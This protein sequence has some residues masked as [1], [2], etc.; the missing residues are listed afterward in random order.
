VVGG[1]VTWFAY[2]GE[3]VLAEY[4]DS[5]ALDAFQPSRKFVYGSYVDEPLLLLSCSELAGGGRTETAYYYHQDRNFNVIAMTDD[6]GQVV[7]QYSYSAYGEIETLT[8]GGTKI[9]ANP[10]FFTG[11]RFDAELTIY[12]YRARYHDPAL[13]RFL[14]RDPLGYVDGMSLYEYVKGMPLISVDPHGLED[15]EL[16]ETWKHPTSG[17]VIEEYKNKDYRMGVAEGEPQFTRVN[18]TQ[19]N[20]N[21]TMGS[22]IDEVIDQRRSAAETALRKVERGA[23][24]AEDAVQTAVFCASMASP[25]D[26]SILVGWGLKLTAKNAAKVAAKLGKL[27]YKA[28]KEGGEI[29]L[30]NGDEVLDVARSRRIAAEVADDVARSADDVAPKNA[31]APKYGAT[32]EGRPLTKHYGTDT[33]PQRNIPGS[34]V[35]NTINTT[36]G[37]PS[38]SGKTVHYDPANNVT[39]VTGDGGSIVSARKGPPRAGQ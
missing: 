5:G 39:V 37:V 8:N 38:G 31:T 1:A 16:V 23:H 18:R 36:K 4:E 11:R 34:V 2:S 14:S 20:K 30:K 12:Y 21:R 29:V 28:V 17:D 19:A 22:D 3:Q 15:W 25:I 9:T 24:I 33:G 6:T 26:E 27:G 32:P 35:D 10:Y 7:D 13:G